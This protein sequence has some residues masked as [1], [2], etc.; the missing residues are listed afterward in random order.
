MKS[1]IVVLIMM[2][3]PTH[4]LHGTNRLTRTSCPLS[5]C[6]SALFEKI[7][8]PLDKHPRKDISSTVGVLLVLKSPFLQEKIQKQRI[9]ML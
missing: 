9:W 5:P 4:V 8:P 1:D 3:G 6:L 2:G 7:S